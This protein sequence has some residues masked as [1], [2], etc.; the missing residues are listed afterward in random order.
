MKL[1]YFIIFEMN[2]SYFLLHSKNTNQ[3]LK[4]LERPKY[5][6]FEKIKITVCLFVGILQGFYFAVNSGEE[7]CLNSQVFSPD[8]KAAQCPNAE[9]MCCTQKTS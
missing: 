1:F 6:S 2:N 8:G 5:Y 9:N 7:N 4:M 3:L